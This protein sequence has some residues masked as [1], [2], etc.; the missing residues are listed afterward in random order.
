MPNYRRAKIKGGTYFF[1]VVTYRRRKIL[2]AP[3]VRTSLRHA[4]R[5]VRKI[6]PFTIE[7]WVLLPDHLHCIWALPQNDAE[8]GKRWAMI[9]TKV[10]Q[11]CGQTRHRENWMTDVKQ[12][13]NESTLWQR[14]YW[15]HTIRDEED[16][17]NH[18][19][20]IHYNPVKHGLV[21]SV[22]DWPFSTFH[23]S[24]KAGLYEEHW[25]EDNEQWQDMDFGE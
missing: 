12:R 10:T 11:D 15:E 17:F 13:R 14:R 4:I 23:R 24:L 9:K 25:G 5:E 2:C 20:Y 3:E 6:L 21:K 8:F 16:Y 22:K 7:A 18:M 19:H 1:T